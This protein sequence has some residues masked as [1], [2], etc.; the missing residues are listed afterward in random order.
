MGVIGYFLPILILGTIL[1]TVLLGM[2]EQWLTPKTTYEKWLEEK[3]RKE[4][5]YLDFIQ[6][7][8]DGKH[9]KLGKRIFNK[10]ERGKR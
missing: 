7:A 10:I 5:V 2:L 4:P 6:I 8:D 3:L 9:Y 1:I